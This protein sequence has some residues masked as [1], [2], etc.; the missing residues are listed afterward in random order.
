MTKVAIISDT[1]DVLRPQVVEKLKE[2]DMILHGGDIS[3]QEILEQ[4]EAIAPVYAV[5]G[6]NDKDWAEDLPKSRVIQIEALNF[7]L[8]HDRKDIPKDMKGVDVIIYG[9]SHQYEEET[10]KDGILMLNPGSCGK[11]RFHYELTMCFLIAGDDNYT[12]EKIV[13]KPE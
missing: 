7:Y 5:R 6:N 13:I 11:K 1:H 9:H 12:F 2:A 3:S 10:T 4:L 8:V